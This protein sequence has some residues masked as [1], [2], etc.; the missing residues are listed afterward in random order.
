MEAPGYGEEEEPINTILGKVCLLFRLLY[1]GT[2]AHQ[3]VYFGF[4]LSLKENRFKLPLP[5]KSIGHKH[6]EIKAGG[7]AVIVTLSTATQLVLSSLH[8]HSL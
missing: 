2:A 8:H 3:R 5:W 4:V 1:S 6:D 7:S